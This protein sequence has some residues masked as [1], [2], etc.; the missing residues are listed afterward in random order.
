MSKRNIEELMQ[1]IVTEIQK[2]VKEEQ[3]EKKE[4]V[5]VEGA[6]S[7]VVNSKDDNL[8]RE[9]VFSTVPDIVKDG[10][11]AQHDTN[12]Y[13]REYYFEV[14]YPN[15][16]TAEQM[17]KLAV[18]PAIVNVDIKPGYDIRHF[19]VQ[20]TYTKNEVVQA[21]ERKKK[22]TTIPEAQT[23]T[24]D[25]VVDAILRRVDACVQRDFDRQD[26]VTKT[27]VPGLRVTTISIPVKS[28]VSLSAVRGVIALGVIPRIAFI[29]SLKFVNPIIK[30]DFYT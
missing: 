26:E 19:G 16:I 28:S 30:I 24:D 12:T 27:V 15:E 3:K 29:P 2:R 10:E 5:E 17:E 4:E 6:E 20:I 7:D 23:A 1:E 13:T 18:L 21:Y 11:L 8:V 22:I 14:Q 9:L 25:A